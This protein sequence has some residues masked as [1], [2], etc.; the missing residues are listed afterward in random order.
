MKLCSVNHCIFDNYR[1][2]LVSLVISKCPSHESIN[3]ILKKLSDCFVVVEFRGVTSTTHFVD[4]LMF[5]K[6]KRRYKLHALLHGEIAPCEEKQL[7]VKNLVL[8]SEEEDQHRIIPE[9]GRPYESFLGS[10][11]YACLN[12]QV[13]TPVSVIPKCMTTSQ[14]RD[15]W[16]QN[17][18]S[19]LFYE[20][21]FVEKVLY[22]DGIDF[23]HTQ[24]ECIHRMDSLVLNYDLD[25]HEDLLY[26]WYNE[27]ILSIIKMLDTD[28]EYPT[29]CG[30][31]FVRKAYLYR[32]HEDVPFFLKSFVFF[33]PSFYYI[34]N[35]QPPFYWSEETTR[36]IEFKHHNNGYCLDLEFIGP[37]IDPCFFNLDLLFLNVK[38]CLPCLSYISVRGCGFSRFIPNLSTTHHNLIVGS[39]PS[40]E[41]LLLKIKKRREVATNLII[42]MEDIVTVRSENSHSRKCRVL[43]V[44]AN[45]I[46]I[47]FDKPVII[48]DIK[49]VE[50]LVFSI[51]KRSVQLRSMRGIYCD[52]LLAAPQL[53]DDTMLVFDTLTVP[54]ANPLRTLLENMKRCTFRRIKQ[55]RDWNVLFH[56]IINNPVYSFC[57]KRLMREF[58]E[59]NSSHLF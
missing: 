31:G 37:F 38:R 6:D 49:N 17:T 11:K 47:R 33:S 40:K 12:N 2:E 25:W 16:L 55:N 41:M 53:Q 7:F 9:H 32:N 1:K 57:R 20:S 44:N 3:V 5:C 24:I 51:G 13:I 22:I 54:V 26:K 59:L 35:D 52:P 48:E 18:R 46:T 14:E 28:N 29:P 30:D 43:F 58:E 27:Y 23:V 50:K 10:G 8:L 34:N 36:F 45:L 15:F 4:P 56:E 42:D 19:F 39:I 21:M